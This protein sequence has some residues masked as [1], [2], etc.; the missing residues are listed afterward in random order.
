MNKKILSEVL[1]I[2]TINITSGY[3]GLMLVAPGFL[4]SKTFIDFLNTTLINLPLSL[5]GFLL[6]Y[7]LLLKK[8]K[9]EFQSK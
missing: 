9:Y 5:I 2:I 8:E 1:S 6:S 7:V 3:I 4:G